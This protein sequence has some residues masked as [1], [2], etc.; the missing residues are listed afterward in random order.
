VSV[1]ADSFKIL[2][3]LENLVPVR[4]LLAQGSQGFATSQTLWL[5]IRVL[6]RDGSQMVGTGFTGGLQSARRLGWLSSL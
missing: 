6:D 4:R 3:A 2:T 1:S 5:V